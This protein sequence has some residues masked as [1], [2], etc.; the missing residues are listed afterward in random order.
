MLP[1][2]PGGC[3][4]SHTQTL[5]HIQQTYAAHTDIHTYEWVNSIYKSFRNKLFKTLQL[6]IDY[7]YEACSQ[8]AASSS[9][10][11]LHLLVHLLYL[12]SLFGLLSMALK[13]I[14]VHLA[15]DP[16]VQTFQ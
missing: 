2:G 7:I 10:P 13:P 5:T 16:L 15:A 11:I 12:F 9:L 8:F 4:N 3:A 1:T 14:D 6:F